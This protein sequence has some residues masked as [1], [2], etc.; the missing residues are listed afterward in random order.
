MNKSINEQIEVTL[1]FMMGFLVLG[2]EGQNLD[3]VSYD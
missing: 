2:L 3:K 1:H